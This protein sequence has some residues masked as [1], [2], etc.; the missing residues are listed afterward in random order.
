M[1]QFDKKTR[2]LLT[3]SR[4]KRGRNASL[5]PSSDTRAFPSVG[6]CADLDEYVAEL[7]YAASAYVSMSFDPFKDHFWLPSIE[8]RAF[9][10][11]EL[12][13][14]VRAPR[15]NLARAT[16]PIAPDFFTL[17]PGDE[18]QVTSLGLSRINSGKKLKRL[19]ATFCPRGDLIE[20]DTGDVLLARAGTEEIT[21]EQVYA[22]IAALLAEFAEYRL[23][24]T[25]A[26]D[27]DSRKVLSRAIKK[28]RAA[29]VAL[30]HEDARLA[31]RL[32][33]DAVVAVNDGFSS[34]LEALLKAIDA[35]PS[36][37]SPH[38]TF[39]RKLEHG[40]FLLFGRE[41]G[42]SANRKDGPFARFAATFFA[43]VGCPIPGSTVLS[44]LGP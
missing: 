7:G 4:R 16:K 29:N 25:R 43:C 44:R 41:A 28:L 40:Y 10:A 23:V 36:I 20:I 30:R 15:L 12:E 42:Q 8:A 26:V 3:R 5:D 13:R 33:A 38:K 18:W 6:D 31:H 27:S 22:A 14:I 32:G 1:G 37:Q 21:L 19:K 9:S 34:R 35:R 11:G 24:A 2:K 17:P 39:I